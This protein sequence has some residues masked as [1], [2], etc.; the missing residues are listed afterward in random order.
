M[1]LKMKNSEIYRVY[2]VGKPEKKVKFYS[3]IKISFSQMLK[4]RLN[5]IHRYFHSLRSSLAY[6]PELI[7]N[8]NKLRL[9]KYPADLTK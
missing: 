6:G 8:I 9:F 4:L 2:S 3:N 1:K 5:Q 7:R